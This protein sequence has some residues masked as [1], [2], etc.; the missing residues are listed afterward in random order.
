MSAPAEVLAY[1]QTLAWPTVAIA[2]FL[3]FRK[4]IG[5]LIPQIE[6]VSAGGASVK[7]TKA[8]AKLSNEASS[9]A[10][11][12]IEKAPAS[13]QLPSPPQIV[14]PTALFLAAYGQLENSARD[15]APTAGIKY[16]NPNP[17]QVLRRLAEKGM[18]PKET[19]LV[20][21]Q[22]RDIRNEVAHGVRPLEPVD[23]ENLADTARSLAL[24]CIAAIPRS[25]SML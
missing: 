6:E 8:V 15:A 24:I 3:I 12:V 7:F 14:D 22:L 9:L 16:P 5:N 11:R 21:S 2:G 25:S 13:P 19:V 23:A 17:V 10:E 4:P 18:I 20:A 1:F